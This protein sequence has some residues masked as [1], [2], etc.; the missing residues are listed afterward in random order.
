L[1]QETAWWRFGARGRGDPGRVLRRVSETI[2]CHE[3]FHDACHGAAHGAGHDARHLAPGSRQPRRTV[4]TCRKNNGCYTH[5]VRC[6]EHGL[7]R[8]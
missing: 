5:V 7:S 4:G 2:A 1:W 8:C 6:I 3:A